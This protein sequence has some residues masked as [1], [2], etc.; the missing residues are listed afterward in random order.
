[1]PEERPLVDGV[2]DPAIEEAPAGDSAAGKRVS[3][4]LR[5]LTRAARS[6]L[7]YEPNNAT[8]RQFLEVLRMAMRGVLTDLGALDLE[9]RP[10]ELLWRGEVV[11]RETDRERSLAFRLFRDGVRRLAIGPEASWE[12]VLRLLEVLSVRYTRVRQNEDDVVTLLRKADLTHVEFDV[13]EGFVPEDEDAPAEQPLE[14]R[15]SGRDEEASLAISPRWDLPQRELPDLEVLEWREIDATDRGTLVQEEGVDAFPSNSVRAVRALLDLRS[16]EREGDAEDIVRFIAEVRDFLLGE[17][18]L[19]AML[20]LVRTLYDSMALA[21]ERAGPAL[22][23]FSDPVVLRRI[24]LTASGEATTLPAE[25]AELFDLLPIDHLGAL[26]DLLEEDFP[27][28]TRRVLRQVLERY[29]PTRPDYVLSRLRGAQ[30]RAACDLLRACARA[31]PDRAVDAAVE[32]AS[33][34]DPEV[35]D[36]ALR[37]FEDAP[38]NPRVGRTLA[39]LLRSSHREVRRRALELLAQR[40]E[41]AAFAAVSEHV[42][43][44]ANDLIEE[45]EVALLGC[46]LARLSPESALQLFDDWLRSKG[47][48][49]RWGEG[50]AAERLARVAVSGLQVIPGEPAAAL[51][52]EVCES[53]DG[54]VAQRA[55]AALARR[56]SGEG[57]HG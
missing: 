52:R 44:A 54:V 9:V 17:G 33:H 12:E 21:R 26:I 10:F 35:L 27:P 29:I 3:E 43:G 15:P 30:A 6:F 25:A 16:N 38:A 47:R 48:I 23:G 46:T 7:L 2:P 32:L 36:E 34:S 41:R 19:S 40:R 51:L 28:Q 39:Q 11:Y 55:D 53:G 49:R 8:V 22:R 56:P 37:R 45:E 14:A 4:A 24:V 42:A 13:V 18:E 5:S 1:M 31:I 20:E 50:S 57:G